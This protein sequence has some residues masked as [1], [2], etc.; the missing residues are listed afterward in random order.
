MLAAKSGRVKDWQML[1]D[2]GAEI[3]ADV[4]LMAIHSSNPKL[5]ET[6][7]EHNKESASKMLEDIIAGR[8]IVSRSETDIFAETLKKAKA[9]KGGR[10]AI[11]MVMETLDNPDGIS[12]YLVILLDVMLLNLCSFRIYQ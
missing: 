4:L 3:D 6:V 10:R 12:L 2:N 1:I 9:S 11:R 7:L 8:Y 5:V